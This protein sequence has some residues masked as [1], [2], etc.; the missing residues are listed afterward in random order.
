[1]RHNPSIA[2]APAGHFLCN[3]RI[4]QAY[5]CMYQPNSS[6]PQSALYLEVPQQEDYK[7]HHALYSTSLYNINQH[8]GLLELVS[9][10]SSHA[11]CVH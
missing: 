4:V 7:S 2:I 9:A 6:P 1:M 3:P 5:S 8:I 11:L 10:H